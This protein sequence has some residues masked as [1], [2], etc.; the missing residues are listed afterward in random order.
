MQR[1]LGRRSGLMGTLVLA[2]A[3]GSV[4][5]PPGAAEAVTPGGYCE[6]GDAPQAIAG[7]IVVPEGWIAGRAL[8]VGAGFDEAR[9]WKPGSLRFHLTAPDGAVS[10][11][12]PDPGEADEH[13]GAFVYTPPS[14]GHYTLSA[15][16]TY[17]VCTDPLTYGFVYVTDTAGPVGFD[18]KDE[19]DP[20]R[21]KIASG[22]VPKKR[23]RASS[24]GFDARVQCDDTMTSRPLTTAVYFE[25]GG[26]V[27]THRS[28]HLTAVAAIGCSGRSRKDRFGLAK[29]SRY[30]IEA[31]PNQVYAGVW[32]PQSLRILVETRRGGKLLMATRA[33]LRSARGRARS[34]RDD[35]LCPQAP[36]GCQSFTP[37]NR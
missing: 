17:I 6:P 32:S 16:S 9:G 29:T 35:A 3:I 15:E 12:S 26:R 33:I 10:D 23:L 24:A 2:A 22:S 13:G 19:V 34:L 14:A 25:L 1:R 21:Y 7:K 31:N 18:V 28:R 36:D 11:V 5:L 8:R 27:P 37:D 20:T 4:V 30:L